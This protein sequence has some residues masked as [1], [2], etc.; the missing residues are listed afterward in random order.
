MASSAEILNSI[1]VEEI[2]KSRENTKF[3]KGAKIPEGINITALMDE[4][5]CGADI[6][7][8]AVP[9]KYLRGILQQLKKIKQEDPIY[10]SAAKGIES[11]T[12]M[13]MSEV[14]QDVLG[15]DKKIVAIS[16]PSIAIEV[17]K[18]LPTT[19]ADSAS[20]AIVGAIP[21]G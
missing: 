3:L 18:G 21:L 9:S 17:A 13:R 15:G 16:G 1:N 5:L 4:A 8:L 2:A 12:L 7:I 6:V 20:T 19:I 11:D 14:I 10:I